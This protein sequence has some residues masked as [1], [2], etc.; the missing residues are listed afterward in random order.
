MNKDWYSPGS[1]MPGDREVNFK[2]E[3][4]EWIIEHYEI[5][6]SGRWVAKQ[7]GYV[8]NPFAPPSRQFRAGAYFEDP[9]A[10]MAEFDSRLEACGTDGE[11]FRLSRCLQYEEDRLCLLLRMKAQEISRINDR[12]FSYIVG[13]KKDRPY[14]EFVRHYS[15]GYRGRFRYKKPPL[16]GK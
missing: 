15:P 7:S 4:I 6:S 5:L 9:A 13:K 1:L 12:V 16:S 2:P 3:Q 11:I 14:T 10:L 8:D